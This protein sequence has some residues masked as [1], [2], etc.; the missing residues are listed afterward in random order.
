MKIRAAVLNQ[1]GLSAPYAQSRPLAIETLDLGAP[2]KGEVLVRIAAAGLCH[3]DLSVINGDRPRPVPMAL[4]HEAAGVVEQVG[5][6]VADLAPGD[7]V[8][9]VF[10]PSCG[11]CGPCA[12]GRPALC[13]PGAAAN[14]AGTLVSGAR[15]LS[16]NGTAIQH[17]MGVSAF[18]DHAIVSRRSLVRIDPELPLDE[19]ALFGCAVL[20]GVGAVVNTARVPPGSSVAVLGLGGVGLN[21]LLAAV[22]SGAEKIIALDMIESKLQLARQL[23]ATHAVNAGDKDAIEQVKALTQG[24]VDYAFEMAGSVAALELAYRITRRGGTTVT[25]GLPNPQSNWPLQAVTL[26][27]E[28]RTVKGSYIGSCVPSR[29][30]PRYIA[31]YRAGKLPVDKLMSARIALDDIN[32]GFDRLASGEAVRQVI[33][34]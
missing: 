14:T 10:V 25:A 7:H 13:E 1:T 34:F 18:A 3:S 33:V 17:H 12:E 24:G 30:V 6:D 15:R 22:A 2:G 26:V 19:A 23:G 27:A 9:M 28:E 5:E 11:H 16:R 31:L 4:G 20:T 21:S 32:A 29:D 8:V